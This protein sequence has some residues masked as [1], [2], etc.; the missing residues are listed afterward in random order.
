MYRFPP[1]K[2]SVDKSVCEKLYISFEFSLM[3]W[4]WD[5]IEKKMEEWRKQSPFL[6]L[7]I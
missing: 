2:L 7:T 6:K 3:N 1:N 4:T 5:L